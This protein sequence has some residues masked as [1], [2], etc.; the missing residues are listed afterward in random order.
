MKDFKWYLLEVQFVSA[1]RIHNP[2]VQERK[3]D[4]E[5]EDNGTLIGLKVEEKRM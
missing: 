3:L 1:H 4:L 2:N 5:L